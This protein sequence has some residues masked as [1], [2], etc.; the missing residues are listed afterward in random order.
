M[1]ERRYNEAEV[2]A[3]F[4]RA[5]EAQN[6]VQSQLPSGEGMTLTQIQEIGREVGFTPEQLASAAKAVA[7]APR[8]TS[9]WFF[10]LPIGVGLTV[11]LDRKLSDQEWE[12][13]I[14]DLRETFDAR[15]RLIQDGSLRQWS[16]GNLQAFVEPTPTGDRVR[17]RTVKGDSRRL[18]TVGIAMLGVSAVG[19]I[20]TA[21]G[22]N[23]GGLAILSA[24]ALFATIGAAMFAI[25]GL[26]L[27]GWA[28]LR[29]K[30][31]QDVAS[32]VAVVAS[33]PSTPTTLPPAP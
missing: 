1:T 25:G 5:A 18:M 26:R 9:R 3:I 29:R 22:A 33:L 7:F 2:S 14:V 12:R 8:P 28:R 17:M 31:M 15:G 10:G 24:P 27:P 30:Q 32:R 6:R 11:D 19:A 4:E 13:L 21:T 23:T 20:A 16:N